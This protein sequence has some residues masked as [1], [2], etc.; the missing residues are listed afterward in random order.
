MWDVFV[1]LVVEEVVVGVDVLVSVL[2][3]VSEFVG[4]LVL[5]VKLTSTMPKLLNARFVTLSVAV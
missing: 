4:D 2:E 5:F 3:V 1:E